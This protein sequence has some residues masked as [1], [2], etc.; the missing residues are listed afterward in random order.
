MFGSQLTQKQL[1]A[2]Q[3]NLWEYLCL[4]L[5]PITL[6]FK[7]NFFSSMSMKK[8]MRTSSLCKALPFILLTVPQKLDLTYQETGILCAQIDTHQIIL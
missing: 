5:K 2:A 7:L 1:C 6:V 4:P 3:Q 8:D